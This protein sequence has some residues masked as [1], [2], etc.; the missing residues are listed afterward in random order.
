MLAGPCPS[1][2]SEVKDPS[3]KRAG[4]K[5]IYLGAMNPSSSPGIC[6]GEQPAGP[7]ALPLPSPPCLP[8]QPAANRPQSPAEEGGGGR[9]T[10]DKALAFAFP[11]LALNTTALLSAERSPLMDNDLRCAAASYSSDKGCFY[12]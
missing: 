7:H 3:G 6:P 1:L 9:R 4:E 11:P 8:G 12:Y 5:V 10:G 2:R